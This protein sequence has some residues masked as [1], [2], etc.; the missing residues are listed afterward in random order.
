MDLHRTK[1]LIMLL[2]AV[3]LLLI[4]L[5][6]FCKQFWMLMGG[7]FCFLLMMAVRLLFNRCPHCKK[8]LGDH[9]GTRCPHCGKRL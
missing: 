3:C 5:F 7:S 1:L 2:T 4:T 8:P 9:T 6:V